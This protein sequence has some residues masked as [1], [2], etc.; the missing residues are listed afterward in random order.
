MCK[1]TIAKTY[2]MAAVILFAGTCWQASAQSGEIKPFKGWVFADT[3]DIQPR[4]WADLP[5]DA[6]DILSELILNDENS[7]LLPA[8]D[9]P[10]GLP[11]ELQ[12]LG[13]MGNNNVGGNTKNDIFGLAHF[14]F[15]TLTLYLWEYE[16]WTSDN[17]DKLFTK[18]KLVLNTMTMTITGTKTVVGGTGGFE[19]AV[20]SPIKTFGGE[21]NGVAA[22]TYDGWI[23]L[24]S[25]SEDAPA[26]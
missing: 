16:V 22:L 8:G 12:W 4:T 25:P 6:N 7:V 3:N 10:S 21:A 15:P 26:N 9:G 20:S 19:G 1:R 13:G 5:E 11:S 23:C 14:H 24:N 2:L 18:N 17:G